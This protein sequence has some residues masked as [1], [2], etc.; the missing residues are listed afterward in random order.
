[1]LILGGTVFFQHSAVFQTVNHANAIILGAAGQQAK[2][3]QE[4]VVQFKALR[5]VYVQLQIEYAMTKGLLVQTESLL[6]ETKRQYAKAQGEISFLRN[7][8]AQA[9]IETLGNNV[10]A[11]TAQRDSLRDDLKSLQDEISALAAENPESFQAQT[12]LYGSRMD[13][14]DIRM[15]N[16]KYDTLMARIGDQQKQIATTKKRIRELKVE[17]ALVKRETQQKK[18]E[19]AL[20]QGNRGFMT[21]EG[22]SINFKNSSSAALATKADKAS[23]KKVNVNVS[24]F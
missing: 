14:L 20:Q 4:L 16:L 2:L 11:L 15:K 6:E 7:A 21:R 18:N 1:M 22:K 24:F 3:Y 8:L 10:R 9:K 17:A 5:S 23:E 13:A 19:I 12:V